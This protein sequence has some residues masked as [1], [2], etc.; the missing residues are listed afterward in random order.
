VLINLLIFSTE[1]EES[2][3][4]FKWKRVGVTNFSLGPHRLKGAIRKLRTT[5]HERALIINRREGARE[6]RLRNENSSKKNVSGIPT[7]H[8]AGTGIQRKLL[9]GRHGS[10][11]KKELNMGRRLRGKTPLKKLKEIR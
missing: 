11:S 6:L 8:P 3:D 7:D 10:L 5:T 2:L 9:R 4:R 1:G